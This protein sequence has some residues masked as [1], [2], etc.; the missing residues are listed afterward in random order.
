LLTYISH[1]SRA[2]LAEYRL[3][4]EPR[5][6]SL[7][8][9]ATA[10][11]LSNHSVLLGHVDGSVSFRP[12]S[13][14]RT[15]LGGT[16][17]GEGE[18]GGGGGKRKPPT[19]PPSSVPYPA[20]PPILPASPLAVVGNRHA[21][22]PVLSLSSGWTGCMA[23]TPS[24]GAYI[25]G[26][27]IPPLVFSP[28]TTPVSAGKRERRSPATVCALQSVGY[29]CLL[30]DMAGGVS[31]IDV[32]EPSSRC[33]PLG[34]HS[35]ASAT[36]VGVRQSDGQG[37]VTVLQYNTSS[38]S[39]S[40]SALVGR[41]SGALVEYD[42]RRPDTP[43]YSVGG[44]GTVIPAGVSAGAGSRA[45]VRWADYCRGRIVSLVSGV[46]RVHPPST[47]TSSNGT[48]MPDVLAQNVVSAGACK[49]GVFAVDSLNQVS[50]YKL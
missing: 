5:V 24:R 9:T 8:S 50:W 20:R 49:E 21:R 37:A 2:G 44:E 7:P 27:D 11:A 33:V 26:G 6:S 31:C 34:K 28:Y 17:E 43:L 23:L 15:V 41:Q 39:L 48:P 35:P 16:E 36:G 4:Q 38:Q 45:G 29:Q 10:L 3:G 46:L 19:L 25:Q 18:G 30:G 12:T 13:M 14:R 40:R 32:R 47:S 42:L 22:E 1:I